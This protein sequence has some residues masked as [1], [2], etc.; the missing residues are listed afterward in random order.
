MTQHADREQRRQV[1]ADFDN[2]VAVLQFELDHQANG[3][4]RRDRDK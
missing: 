1:D 2:K 3:Q 4:N